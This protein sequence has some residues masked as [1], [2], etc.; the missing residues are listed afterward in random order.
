VRRKHWREDDFKA[1]FCRL[2]AARTGWSPAACE[3][4][5]GLPGHRFGQEPADAV[6]DYIEGAL[7]DLDRPAAVD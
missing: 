3:A 7:R 5:Y 4:A 2:L 1:A 6:D